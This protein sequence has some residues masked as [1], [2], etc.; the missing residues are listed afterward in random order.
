M[1][2]PE[3]DRYKGSYKDDIEEGLGTKT[4]QDQSF[5]T[6]P[7]VDGK[8]EGRGTKEWPELWQEKD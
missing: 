5:Q 8:L 4:W 3:Y 2:H 7:H 6:G 1:D